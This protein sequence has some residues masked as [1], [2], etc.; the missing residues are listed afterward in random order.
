MNGIASAI[1]MRK[2]G[3]QVGPGVSFAIK[4]NAKLTPMAVDIRVA[5][6]EA[7]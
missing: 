4:N 7:A 1:P 3:C 5:L 2:H 6:R